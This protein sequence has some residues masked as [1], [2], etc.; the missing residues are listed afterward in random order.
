MLSYPSMES[1]TVSCF[2][3]NSASIIFKLGSEMKTF[4]GQNTD[5]QMNKID[6]NKIE[7]A[8]DEFIKFLEN[9]NITMNIDDFS[10][11]SREIFEKEELYLNADGFK[12]FSMLTLAFTQLGIIEI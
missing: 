3:D 9:E 2:K 7:H 11:A 10:E 1:Y 4:T 6:E 5:I 12:L 8:A